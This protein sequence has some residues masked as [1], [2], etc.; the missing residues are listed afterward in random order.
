MNSSVVSDAVTRTSALSFNSYLTISKV[1]LSKYFHA[2]YTC[3]SVAVGL[4][5]TVV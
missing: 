2:S 1:G 5:R 4:S 3:V